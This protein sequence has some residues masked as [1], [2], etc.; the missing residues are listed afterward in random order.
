MNYNTA[1]ANLR[2]L[3]FEQQHKQH[4]RNLFTR[5]HDDTR[6]IYDESNMNWFGSAFSKNKK[7]TSKIVNVLNEFHPS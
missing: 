3:G 4:Q 6:I 7:L 2:M 5:K 1:I